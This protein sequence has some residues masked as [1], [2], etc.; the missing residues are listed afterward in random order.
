[1]GAQPFNGYMSPQTRNQIAQAAGPG[2]SPP[3]AAR[4]AATIETGKKQQLRTAS[5]RM[6]RIVPLK[7]KP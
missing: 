2:V 6:A 3:A 5:S 7:K 4:M 1:M